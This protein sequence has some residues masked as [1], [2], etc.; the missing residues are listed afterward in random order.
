MLIKAY[1]KAARLR[2][3]PLALAAVALGGILAAH[4]GQHNWSITVLAALTAILLQILSNFA[5]DYGDFRSGVDANRTDRALGGGDLTLQQ[6][7]TA[8]VIITTL[9]TICGVSLIVISFKELSVLSVL[10]FIIGLLAI[11]AA[12]KYTAGKNPY[13]YRGLG[14]LAVLI[15][16]GLVPVTGLYYMHNP[17]VDYAFYHSL[18]PAA[19]FGLLSAGVLNINNIRDID[20]DLAMNKRTLATYLGAN[21][22]L[23]YQLVLLVLAYG[24]MMWFIRSSSAEVG[25]TMWLVLPV[26]LLQWIA[27]RN[28]VRSAAERSVFNK[29]LKFLVLTNLVFVI[30]FGILLLA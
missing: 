28:A 27:L 6:M 18:L 24:L 7:K 23:W 10:Y 16:F 20:S 11:A 17:V 12:F 21:R 29:L 5:N 15:F 1:V 26:H 4:F 3:L 25:F 8:L 19:A 30:V 2:T 22:A 13:G 14:D 9:S